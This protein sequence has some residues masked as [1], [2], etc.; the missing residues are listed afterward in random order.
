MNQ[1]CNSW[2][3]QRAPLRVRLVKR[4]F[5]MVASA[6][7][8]ALCLPLFVLVAAAVKF[9][10][11][12]PVFF[13][14]IRV[15][16]HGRLFHIVKF[17]TMRV[18]SEGAGPHF[19]AEGD[20]RV[21]RI[22]KFLRA[23]KFNELPQLINVLLGDMSLVGPRPETPELM[24]QYTLAQRAT[25]LSVRPGVTD[26]ASILLRNEGALLSRAGDP[27]RFYR[28]VL[29]PVRHELCRI[30]L[31]EMGFGA[32]LKIILMTLTALASRQPPIEPFE[33]AQNFPLNERLELQRK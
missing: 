17:R 9:D 18:G 5:D 1:P 30:Y 13:R 4:V 23:A 29:M 26:Y 25:F 2:T 31:S 19:T 27:A 7:G 8:L 33:T 20:S 21:T 3:E 32:D 28:E 24:L 10:S 22:G 6:A 11:R 16:R 15:G 14:Q 12:G